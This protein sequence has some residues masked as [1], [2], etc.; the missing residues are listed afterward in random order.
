MSD[1]AVV[2]RILEL[3]R[4]APSGDNTQPWR[5]EIIAND[6]VRVRAYDTRDWCVYDLEGRASQ[7][8]VGALL[9]SM[10]IAAS[11]ERM[12]ARID[13]APGTSDSQL[14]IDVHFAP[15]EGVGP[16]L[17]AGFL[18]SRVTHRR[19]FSS[20][21]LQHA[22][23]DGLEASVAQVYS[24]AGER[25]KYRI[26]WI[27]GKPSKRRM[28]GLLFRNAGIRLTIPEAYRVHERIIEWNADE[29]IDRIPDRA[30]G[31][32]AFGLAAMKLA[33]KSWER[34]QFANRYL[35]GTLLPRL[36]MDVRPALGCAAHFVILAEAAPE[37]LDDYLSA[38]RAVQRF[39]LTATSLGLQFQ[40]EMTP[41][42][43][44]RYV[45]DGVRFSED[46]RALRT[47]ADLRRDL[48]SLLR[49]HELRTAVFM[50]RVGYGAA[51]KA[52]SIRLPL[53]RLL[54]PGDKAG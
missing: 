47:A 23:R 11:L 9:E 38:G 43:F 33:M 17:L 44:S 32:N 54:I 16:D 37:A 6:R 28:A 19:P 1:T 22:H 31:L 4:W 53:E 30:L 41:L 35:G 12:V 24:S 29:S 42:I 50:G 8:A 27:A 18:R 34:V 40:P 5:F 21:P 51:P 46:D 20:A 49:G 13:R 25:K 3:A 15:A 14:L 2:E 39:W 52:R 7:I 36:E 26:A 10:A 45:E 48:G